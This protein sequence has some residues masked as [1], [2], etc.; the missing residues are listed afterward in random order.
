V[1]DG[2][3]TL[4]SAG[5]LARSCLG[6]GSRPSELS[7]I[8]RELLIREALINESRMYSQE[9]MNGHDSSS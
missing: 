3:E 6:L 4:L 1:C 2:H 9:Y 7:A 8:L 5:V